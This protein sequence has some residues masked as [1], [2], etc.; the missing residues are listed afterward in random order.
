MTLAGQ[1]ERRSSSSGLSSG[2]RELGNPPRANEIEVSLFGPGYGESVVL[3][4][5]DNKW[6]IVDSCVEATSK[7]WPRALSYLA[8]L[9]VDSGSA[10]KVIVATHWH[11]DHIRGL[12]DIVS[13]CGSAKFVCPGAMAS[14]EFTT[15]AASYLQR[16]MM[17]ST[18]VQ[19]FG[20]IL[21]T[22]RSRASLGSAFPDPV[23]ASAGKCLWRGETAAGFC[24][25]HALSPSDASVVRAQMEIASLVPQAK[26]SEIRVVAPSPNHSAVALWF[27]VASI[28]VLLGSD[29]E[30]TADDL[31]GWSVIVGSDT[32]PSGRAAVFKVPHHGSSNGDQPLV[33][34]DML[35]TEPFAILTPFTRGRVNLPLESD[36]ARIRSRTRNAYICAPPGS[37]KSPRRPNTVE[38]TIRET[39]GRLNEVPGYNGHIRLRISVGE[40]N[41]PWTVELFG[42]AQNLHPRP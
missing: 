31:T 40:N 2:S 12:S 35:E 36:L 16:H 38:K 11:D 20:S 8:S 3:H 21:R 34:A 30:E 24:A 42:S 5:G 14:K 29:L 37:K 22:L 1:S 6:I 41:D 32:R 13:E 27:E 9:G 39:V 15:L 4:A 7:R 10:V 23:Q 18:G 17:E 28:G 25:L 33:W 26:D 19:E